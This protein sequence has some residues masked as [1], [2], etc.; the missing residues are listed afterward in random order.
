[1]AALKKKTGKT[2]TRKVYRSE[3]PLLPKGTKFFHG[4]GGAAHSRKQHVNTGVI[5]APEGIAKVKIAGGWV[6]GAISG[7][8]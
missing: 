5:W 4:P 7:I 3:V 6:W 1:M 8:F 2:Y